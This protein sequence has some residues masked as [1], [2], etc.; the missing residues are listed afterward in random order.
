MSIS[1][2]SS[3]CPP[4]EIHLAQLYTKVL[5]ELQVLDFLPQLLLS[6]FF[7]T[8]GICPAWT[9]RLRESC[10]VGL[11]VKYLKRDIW[12]LEKQNSKKSRQSKTVTKYDMILLHIMIY[13]TFSVNF[14]I[15]VYTTWLVQA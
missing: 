12:D 1:C 11:P 7:R 10:H 14:E 5:L 13:M 6:V 15:E 8:K 9:V 4:P 2:L 3:V